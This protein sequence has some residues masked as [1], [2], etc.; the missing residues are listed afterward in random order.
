MG[1]ELHA[2]FAH[3]ASWRN[4]V[5]V[6][7][8]NRVV[9]VPIAPV[10]GVHGK[11]GHEDAKPLV[12]VH[13]VFTQ[14]LAVDEHRPVAGVSIFFL[15]R[16][17]GG[18]QHVGGAFAIGMRDDLDAVFVAPVHGVLNLF[19]RHRS[20]TGITG[21]IIADGIV[22]GPVSQGGKALWRAVDGQLASAHAHFAFVVARNMLGD[23]IL[24][25]EHVGIGDNV[26]RKTLVR[27]HRLQGFD[28]RP[29]RAAILCGRISVAHPEVSSGFRESRQSFRPQSSEQR[30]EHIEK[31]IFF[32]NAIGSSIRSALNDTAFRIFGRGGDPR[33]FERLGIGNTE[34]ARLM[35]DHD[36]DFRRDRV[37]ILTRW[38]A[39]FGQLCVVVAEADDHLYLVDCRS[40]LLRPGFQRCLQAGDIRDF[41]VR[42]RK[43]VRRKGLNSAHDH[44]SVAIYE[45]R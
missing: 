22:V 45:P 37:E 38:M 5:R 23:V 29:G 14:K 20:I 4:I 27:V 33:E 10:E 31:G 7:R 43:Q 39:E 18:N 9:S 6:H 2:A 8:A 24:R 3:P 13:L 32:K 36:R 15:G 16:A 25:F 41:A 34:V 35:H 40:V 12:A 42:R 17:N 30:D 1:A 26:H 19:H 44:V 21:R 28:H 11:Q